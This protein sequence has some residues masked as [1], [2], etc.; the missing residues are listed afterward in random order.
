[1]ELH[2]TIATPSYNAGETHGIKRYYNKWNYT[3]PA[4]HPG[5]TQG[6]HTAS[7]GVTSSQHHIHLKKP[8]QEPNPGIKRLVLLHVLYQGVH[9]IH[10]NN[11]KKK[12][13]KQTLNCK[14][15]RLLTITSSHIQS[16]PQSCTSTHK[17]KLMHPL[18]SASSHIHSQP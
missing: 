1:M 3:I 18:K 17:L 16:Q 12:H 8:I 4:P 6:N 11:N 7:N 9:R 14:L 5:T 15:A 2:H 10:Y 13:Y